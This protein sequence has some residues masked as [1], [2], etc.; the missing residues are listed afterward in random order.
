MKS[1]VGIGGNPSQTQIIVTLGPSSADE[2]MIER[3]IMAQIDVVRLNLSWGTHE[4]HKI[5]IDTVRMIAKKHKTNVPII[6]DLSGPRIEDNKGHHFN[7]A[8]MSVITDKDKKDLTFALQN[9]VEYIALSYVGG[10]DDIVE[11]HALIEENGGKA[12]IIAKLERKIAIKNVEEIL[13]VADAIMIARGDLGLE[14]KLESIPF[15]EYNLIQ[16]AN[17][18]KKPVIVATEMM[19]SMV[20]ENK[21]TRSDVTDVAFA[22]ISGADGVM[23]SDE[24]AVGKYPV[25]TVEMMKR[26]LVEA[27]KHA[28][29]IKEEAPKIRL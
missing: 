20:E 22:V 4:E 5:F 28:G 14:L 1:K 29:F 26:I 8:G 10:K 25:E 27:E 18:V 7:S 6:I 3:M 2:E 17:R 9:K 12:K 23:L 11:L 16:I 21:P 15:V 13:E 19:P 24:T